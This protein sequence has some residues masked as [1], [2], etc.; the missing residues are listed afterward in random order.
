MKKQLLEF[1]TKDSYLFWDVPINQLSNLS[2]EFIVAR[3]ID[4]GDLDHIKKLIK[5]IGEEQFKKAFLNSLIDSQGKVRD[6]ILINDYKMINF[7]AHVF[8]LTDEIPLWD[9][10]SKAKKTS[11]FHLSL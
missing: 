8:D 11:T 1:L 10:I 4:W 9:I 3:V 2:L 7:L 5:I 6:R